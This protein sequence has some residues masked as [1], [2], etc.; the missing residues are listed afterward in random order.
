[1]SVLRL[2]HQPHCQYCNSAGAAVAVCCFSAFVAR[3][4]S[5][6]KCTHF[7]DEPRPEC[8]L[9]G[10]RRAFDPSA[11]VLVAIVDVS[12][13]DP[14]CRPGAPSFSFPSSLRGCAALL[15]VFPTLSS[16]AKKQTLVLPPTSESPPN[17]Q[18]YSKVAWHP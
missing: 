9:R 5:N 18:T 7:C 12:R 16:L 17:T 3:Q 8:R 6:H 15:S 1:M 4:T 2:S 13:S 10:C 14:P 11:R